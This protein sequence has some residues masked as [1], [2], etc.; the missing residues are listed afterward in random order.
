MFKPYEHVVAML[1]A[2]RPEALIRAWMAAAGHDRWS[3]L[4]GSTVHV[5]KASSAR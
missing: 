3:R 4:A 2:K 5:G 1:N